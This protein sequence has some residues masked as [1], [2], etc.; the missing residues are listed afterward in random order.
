MVLARFLVWFNLLPLWKRQV[1][2]WGSELRAVSFDRLL[3]LY[4]HRIGWMGLEER[5]FL[6]Q[7][8]RPGMHV[9]DIGANLG[10]YALL[11]SRL[12]GQSGTVVAFEPDPDLFE[13]LETN[14]R[15]NSATNVELCNLAA[16]S[17]S[18]SMWLARS[19]VNAGD[20]RIAQLELESKLTRRVAV[21]SAT[22]DEIVDGRPVDFIKIDVQGWESEVLSGMKRVLTCNPAVQIHLEYWPYGLRE[23]GCDPFELLRGLSRLEFRIYRISGSAHAPITDFANLTEGLGKRSINLY[24]VRDASPQAPPTA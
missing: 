2:V 9:I 22:V 14:C 21:R 23:A 8:V 3:Y 5:T 12:V 24:A 19:L 11:C 18:G 7:K 13:A 4:L 16:A 10:L 15:A 1:R 17:R 6:N 20:N